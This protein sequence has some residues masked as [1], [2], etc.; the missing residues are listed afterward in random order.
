MVCTNCGQC[1][2]RCPTGALTEKTY[3]DQVW[4]AIYDPTKRLLS[5]RHRQ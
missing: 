1:I 4:D 5:R 3:I 2:V